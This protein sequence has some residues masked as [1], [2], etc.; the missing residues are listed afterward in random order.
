MN[1]IMNSLTICI[2]D[3]EDIIHNSLS[4]FIK[5]NVFNVEI[6]SFYSATVFI[7]ALKKNA[8]IGN[9]II[10][11][12]HFDTGISGS[13]AVAEIRRINSNI[14]IIFLTGVSDDSDITY[15][16]DV[17]IHFK[18]KP[19]SEIELKRTIN[20]CIELN[21]TVNGLHDKVNSLELEVLSLAKQVEQT[22][23]WAY[24]ALQS[25][26][27]G[28]ESNISDP[29]EWVEFQNKTLKYIE[30]VENQETQGNSGKANIFNK[31]IELF[32]SRYRCFD[33]QSIK[34]LATG[35][36]LFE[37]HKDDTDIDFSPMLIAYSKCFESVL[38]V[39]L[40]A[41]GLLL[42]EETTTLGSCIYVISK[43]ITSLGVSSSDFSKWYKRMQA[44]LQLRNK[45]AHP[46]GI[47]KDD[48]ERAKAYLFDLKT[49][50]KQEY[51]LDFL[52]YSF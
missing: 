34:F 16:S 17:N 41:K 1:D 32:R 19:I 11:D 47:S 7:R 52:Q 2:V 12:H 26:G 44:F 36:F 20:E 18:A 3:D 9:L 24:E 10:L 51:L 38:T 48:F 30:A 39:F 28:K 13:E 37:S 50:N 14:P 43:N 45:A 40:R 8:E 49:I 4:S 46:S 27:I 29:K 31:I 42:D 21:T 15:K 25:L 23:E 5:R 33:E 22:K 35:E 6:T